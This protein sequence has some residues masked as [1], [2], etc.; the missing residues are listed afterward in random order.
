MT[1]EQRYRNSKLFFG[2]SL[3]LLVGFLGFWLHGVYQEKLE[4]WNTAVS[5]EWVRVV[6]GV[7]S[8]SFSD[9]LRTVG[10]PGV[11]LQGSV[12][13]D[14][15]SVEGQVFTTEIIL[16][17]STDQIELPDDSAK[18]RTLSNNLLQGK[19]ASVFLQ[20]E[21]TIGSDT[22]FSE[23]LPS[24]AQQ[25]TIDIQDGQLNIL[26]RFQLDTAEVGVRLAAALEQAQLHGAYQLLDLGKTDSSFQDPFVTRTALGRSY[27]LKI[28]PASGYLIYQMLWE[29]LLALLLLAT[30]A[31]AFYYNLYHLRQ[32]QELVL[33][34]QDLVS[35]MTHELRTPL[36]T[37]SAALEALQRFQVLQD[38]VRAQEYVAISKKEVERLSLLVEKVLEMSL[39]EQGKQLLQVES[40]AA[41]LWLE[42]IVQ[43]FKITL[44]Q[45]QARLEW[46]VTPVDLTLQGDRLHLSNVLYNL[47]DNALKYSAQ[48]PA[49]IQVAIRQTDKTLITVQDNGE[50]ISEAFQRRIFEQF[51]RVPKGNVQ[52][53][54]GYGLGLYYV[55][56]II[57]QHGGTIQVKSQLG[58]GSTFKIVLPNSIQ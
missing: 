46:N 16:Q 19:I 38:P 58:K 10:A 1:F 49:V 23:T 55:R 7:E 53:V 11:S 39:L 57:E 21:W 12:P 56:H 20:K 3:L 26:Q 40:I 31:A 47:I 54:K 25:F 51:F 24:T 34:K 48:Q 14:G 5:L 50:G 13:L 2:A 52:T 18:G 6:K 43:R 28:A 33:L 9:L 41:T 36:F 17:D 15:R 44:E 22:V 35:N 27:R 8:E 42:D 32:Q 30:I 37:V 45:Q 4:D 29:L